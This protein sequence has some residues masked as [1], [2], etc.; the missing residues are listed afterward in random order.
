MLHAA[1]TVLGKPC[2][3]HCQQPAR[4]SVQQRGRQYLQ[5][6]VQ[7]SSNAVNFDSPVS[8]PH[9]S[10]PPPVLNAALQQRRGL[11]LGGLA[12]AA[13]C[14]ATAS[15]TA[16]PA[17]AS[18]TVTIRPKPQLKAYT[19]KAGYT[20]TV[21]DSWSLAYD[22]SAD[23]KNPSG[24]QAFF[25]NFRTLETLSISRVPRPEGGLSPEQLLEW[26]LA[27]QRSN[28]STYD[29]KLVSGDTPVQRTAPVAGT[30][31]GSTPAEDVYFE[32]EYSQAIC[33]GLIQEGARGSKRCIGPRDMDLEV[34][35]R[36]FYQ[37]FTVRQ[38]N[39]YIIRG[40]STTQQWQDVRPAAQE[41]VQSFRLPAGL[42]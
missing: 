8:Q 38:D 9:R 15:L 24:T 18:V 32:S 31:E 1:Q 19:L 36:S 13:A 30:P 22:R 28:Q 21:P 3:R 34:V 33:R 10:A 16:W 6:H 11:L 12:S 25:G 42:Q 27:E 23:D 5:Q 7:D 41:A 40:S 2:Q 39:I 37:A 14:V 35:S 4:P 17:E 26:V 20:V 29:F